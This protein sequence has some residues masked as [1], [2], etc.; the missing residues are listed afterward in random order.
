MQRPRVVVVLCM[1]CITHSFM[2]EEEEGK[3]QH[4]GYLCLVS[5][6]VVCVL[7][8]LVSFYFREGERESSLQTE[9]HLSANSILS[10]SF[11]FN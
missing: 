7:M 8:S 6:D 3:K 10:I 9:S 2:E 11:E 1:L 4:L 5:F